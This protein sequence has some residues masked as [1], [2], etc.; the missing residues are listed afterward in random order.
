MLYLDYI[1][2]LVTSQSKSLVFLHLF[3]L[4]PDPIHQKLNRNNILNFRNLTRNPHLHPNW[5]C[6]PPRT[7]PQFS[8][9][10]TSKEDEL[11]VEPPFY[12]LKN[13]ICTFRPC[14]SDILPLPFLILLL[15]YQY[16]ISSFIINLDFCRL[17]HDHVFFFGVLKD[18]VHCKNNSLDCLRLTCS[19]LQPSCHP[20]STCL[21]IAQNF[22]VTKEASWEFLHV[23]C[24]QLSIFFLQYYLIHF[25]YSFLLEL[26]IY[27]YSKYKQLV[28][29]LLFLHHTL[30]QSSENFT[31]SLSLTNMSKCTHPQIIKPTGK[32]HEITPLLAGDRSSKHFNLRIHKFHRI[33]VYFN[34]FCLFIIELS[35][36]TTNWPCFIYPYHIDPLVIRIILKF[37]NH[38][39]TCLY[40]DYSTRLDTRNHI[41]VSLPSFSAPPPELNN[42]KIQ[43]QIRLMSYLGN[44]AIASVLTVVLRAVSLTCHHYLWPLALIYGYKMPAVHTVALEDLKKGLGKSGSGIGSSFK[45]EKKRI[46]LQRIF[47]IQL[48]PIHPNQ[49]FLFY[50][51]FPMNCRA[52]SCDSKICKGLVGYQIFIVWER[53]IEPVYAEWLTS[54]AFIQT[55]N[56]III[57]MKL[58]NAI[59]D[60]KSVFK[61][62]IDSDKAEHISCMNS[63]FAFFFE[64]GNCDATSFLG[65]MD[66]LLQ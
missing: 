66:F 19:M 4:H 26:A 1:F 11:H 34:L 44:D 17:N 48:P 39:L 40:I 38:I 8:V 56:V 24:M 43:Q 14:N 57:E 10:C 35:Q 5:F 27:K 53:L 3:P 41:N 16:N 33:V 65:V 62:I 36:M 13:H 12:D 49:G 37:P 32:C 58:L 54:K 22:G 25:E 51:A 55:L 63:A 60:N 7:V 47:E 52:E 29:L 28:L 18:L 64:K 21:H 46:G 42:L 59:K 50:S 23:N 2:S 45:E 61:M 30:N 6:N 20:T 15:L 31:F 9:S